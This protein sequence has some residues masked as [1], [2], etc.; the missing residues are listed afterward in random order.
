MS[1]RDRARRRVS[2]PQLLLAAAALIG[3]GGS[4]ANY[5]CSG[6][7]GGVA[8]CNGA[9]FICNDGSISGSKKNCSTELGA[10][11]LNLVAPQRAAAGGDCSCRSNNIC[12]GPRGGQYCLSDTG[13]KSYVRR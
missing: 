10:P 12:T 13:A 7:K 9:L 3:S 8:R 1:R 6:G 2:W 5:P 4:A 11:A